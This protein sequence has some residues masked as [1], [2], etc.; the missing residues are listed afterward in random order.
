MGMRISSS[1][2][3]SRV[4]N[5]KMSLIPC[6]KWT[7]SRLS[8]RFQKT[9][10][11]GILGQYCQHGASCECV[12]AT[13]LS[14]SIVASVCSIVVKQADPISKACDLLVHLRISI[15]FF[16]ERVNEERDFPP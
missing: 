7:S 3:E 12:L 11:G 1:K 4:L 6:I 8:R 13:R 16:P 5:W 2:S 14:M 10:H 15:F 9:N